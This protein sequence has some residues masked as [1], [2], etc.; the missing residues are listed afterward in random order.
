MER[1]PKRKRMVAILKEAQSGKPQPSSYASEASRAGRSFVGNALRHC[2]ITHG[3]PSPNGCIGSLNGKRCAEGHNKHDSIDL[4]YAREP[5]EAD[6]DRDRLNR[7]H[8][9][10]GELTPSEFPVE[11]ARTPWALLWFSSVLP[12]HP[13]PPPADQPGMLRPAHYDPS[14]SGGKVGRRSLRS[15]ALPDPLVGPRVRQPDLRNLARVAGPAFWRA[16]PLTPRGLA[17]SA[18]PPQGGCSPR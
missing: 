15:E 11:I 1:H 8:R 7:P 5:I 14:A 3:R 18:A 6:R 16:S 12:L 2:F 10:L 4:H 9:R 17:E 13:L